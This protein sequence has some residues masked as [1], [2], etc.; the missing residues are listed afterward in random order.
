M[1]LAAAK[2]YTGTWTLNCVQYEI[3]QPYIKQIKIAYIYF[4]IIILY[5]VESFF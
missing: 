3:L 5:I 1:W 2:M 4:N